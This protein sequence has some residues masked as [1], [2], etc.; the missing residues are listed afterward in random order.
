MSTESL[1]DT[2]IICIT[3]TVSLAIIVCVLALALK[4]V[5]RR[6]IVLEAAAAN[7]PIELV[8]V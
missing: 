7:H 3:L 1:Y 6:I 5:H 2:D 4:Y 8:N